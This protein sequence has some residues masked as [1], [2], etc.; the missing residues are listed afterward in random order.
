MFEWDDGN[1]VGDDRRGFFVGLTNGNKIEIGNTNVIGVISGAP[2]FIGDAAPLQWHQ[3]NET[4]DFGRPT[5]VQFDG[6]TVLQTSD[7]YDP[8]EQYTPRIFRKEWAAV[9]LLGKII[10]RTAQVLTAGNKCSPNSGGYAVA[11]T[12]YYILEVIRQATAE[13]YGIAKVLVK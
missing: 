3:T 7:D 10:V 1:D 2:G 4:D 6:M 5:T 8:T 9:G 13:K 12:D 11:G